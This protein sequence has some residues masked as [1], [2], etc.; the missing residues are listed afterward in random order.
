M[1]KTN[2]E[3]LNAFKIVMPYINSMTHDDMAVALTDLEKYIGYYPAEKFELDIEYGK[4]I[5]GI[6]A[7]EKC[8]RTRKD[9]YDDIA[10]E[11]YGRA[12]KTIFT[13]IKG[14]ND[15]IIG[16]IS[17]AIDFEDNDK[18]IKSIFGL[19]ETINEVAISVSELA[20]SSE[21]LAESGQMSIERVTDLSDRQ[22]E[23]L[24][25]LELIR[26]IA[27]QTNLLGL[28]A[29]IEAA[30]SG[31]HGRGFSVVAEEV[32]KLATKSQDSVKNIEVILEEMDSSVK[33][34]S[35]SIDTVGA[36]SEEQAANTEEILA[37][38]EQ[39][40]EAAKVL[41]EFV[42]RYYQIDM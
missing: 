41:K 8:I 19:A 23:T 35:S 1:C 13:P 5:E 37:Q 3:I 28:N 22:K 11:V 16:T 42:R 30:R 18:L 6:S 39:I 7:I 17:C 27:T 12:V 15:E 29:A 40:D 36:I 20:S 34:I 38:I 33:Q 9:V 4:P 31:E 21:S 25:I 24:N 26:E 2:E 10:K 32:R 14:V